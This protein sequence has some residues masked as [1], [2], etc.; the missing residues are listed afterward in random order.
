MVDTQEQPATPPEDHGGDERIGLQIAGGLLIFLGW[1]LGVLVNL[2]LHAVAPSSGLVLFGAV[3][4]LPKLGPYSWA[5]FGLGVVTGV[6][7]TVF[8]FL[9]RD[10]TKGRFVLPGYDY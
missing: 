2:L 1:G 6:I 8:L 9:S 10:T 3:R 5:I 4:I 7:G